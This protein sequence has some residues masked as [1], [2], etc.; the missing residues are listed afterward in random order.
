MIFWFICHWNF[1]P[2]V[3]LKTRK[4]WLHSSQGYPPARWLDNFQMLKFA[5]SIS[6]DITR[7]VQPIPPMHSQENAWKLQIWLAS[8]SQILAKMRKIH[9]P[10]PKCK[11]VEKVVRIHQH[12]KLQAIPAMYSEG[13]CQRPHIW[14]VS[15]SQNDAKK[16]KIN[17]PWMKF[18]KFWRWSG[19]ISMPKFRPFQT[20]IRRN[21]MG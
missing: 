18:N 15:L 10:W 13:N 19:Y 2:R 11:A 20:S 12:V 4:V 1:F 17:R 16:S 7:L 8:L 21:S 6:L 9:R 3:H 14:P 5:I